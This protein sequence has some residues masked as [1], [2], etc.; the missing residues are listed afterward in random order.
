M[1]IDPFGKIVAQAS[2][3]EEQILTLDIDRAQVI[4][5]RR[6]FL[7]F[8]IAAPILTALSPAAANLCTASPLPGAWSSA[9]VRIEVY[10][11]IGRNCPH[12]S[13]FG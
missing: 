10:R 11:L 4:A 5:A 1:L 8:A 2:A 12:S 3:T 9:I 6:R 13:G 7:S